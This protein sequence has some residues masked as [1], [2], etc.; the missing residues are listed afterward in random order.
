MNTGHDGSLRTL[1]KLGDGALVRMENMLMMSQATLPL[2]SLRRQIAD[3]IDVVIQVERIS[4]VADAHCFDLSARVREENNTSL[5][6]CSNSSYQDQQ[7]NLIMNKSAK[8]VPS[9]N[10]KAK[11]HQL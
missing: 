6:T 7:G 8:C 1:R 4:M 10:E 2:F 3:T 5:K 9:F 11:Y